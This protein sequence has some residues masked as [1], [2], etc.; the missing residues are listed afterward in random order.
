[1]TLID[2]VS[3]LPGLLFGLDLK[4]VVLERIG[5][6]CGHGL[7]KVPPFFVVLALRVLFS[8]RVVLVELI[9]VFI[10]DFFRNIVVVLVLRVV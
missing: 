1:L 5:D 3:L 7:G 9:F 4:R 10:T 8:V 6:C 2:H